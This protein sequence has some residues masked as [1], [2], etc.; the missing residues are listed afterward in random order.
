VSIEYRLLRSFASR[1]TTE[2]TH[3]RQHSKLTR[4]TCQLLLEI[5]N[6]RRSLIGISQYS[7][8]I[9]Q[10]IIEDWRWMKSSM[11]GTTTPSSYSS[12]SIGKLT[13]HEG[14]R[15]MEMEEKGRMSN[16][17][18]LIVTQISS[19]SV[20]VSWSGIPESDEWS[21]TILKA[22]TSSSSSQGRIA[23]SVGGL[24]ASIK[25]S[26]SQSTHT[27]YSLYI[28]P[29][30]GSQ[31]T[32]SIDQQSRS[33]L[34]LPY[35]C[36]NGTQKIDLLDPGLSSLPLVCSA[37]LWFSLTVRWSCRYTLQSLTSQR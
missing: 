20:T 37:L 35:V 9:H 25:G 4:V 11:T 12:S 13:R 19:N 1:L 5:L 32:V 31:Q 27:S 24:L 15:E 34:V 2:S 8:H 7:F 33:L 36:T 26:T 6:L 21:P 17:A 16:K 3:Y 29:L 22:T 30:S 10:E 18:T 14:E 23:A 28:T